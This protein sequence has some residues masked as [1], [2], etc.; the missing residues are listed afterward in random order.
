VGTKLSVQVTG[1]KTGLDPLTVTSPETDAVQLG[2]VVNSG[3]PTVV[4]TPQVGEEL[5]VDEG[6]WSPSDVSF[7]YQWLANNI[8]ISGAT[9]PTFTPRTTDVGKKLSVRVKGTRPGL[10]TVTVTS[11]QA[12]PVVAGAISNSVAPSTT[13][14]PQVGK[15]F[16][17]DPGTWAP[18]GVTLKYAW[19]ADGVALATALS[20]SYTP[21]PADLGKHLT[22]KVTASKTGYASMSVTTS[23]SAAVAPA[24][25]VNTVAPAISGTAKVGS[26]LTVS[27]G[28]W[29][30]TPS[31][32]AFQWYRDGVPIVGATAQT[33]LLTE[34][35]SGHD[36]NASVTVAKP[37]YA[38]STAAST[39]VEVAPIAVRNTAK[40]KITGTPKVG[41]TLTATPGTWAPAGVTVAYQW[42]AGG[43]EIDGADES[44]FV[45]TSAQVGK[46]LTVRATATRPGYLDGVATSLQTTVV[47]P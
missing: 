10:N 28:S 37:G 34:N 36:V 26:R 33:F 22:V 39:S 45:P 23:P 20:A 14:T 9:S 46:A 16:V 32:F 17:V 8:V 24:E 7:T 42:L 4:G 3:P 15:A 19:Y 40:P 13:G 5:S 25:L 35:E 41:T 6:T 29:S 27:R 44:T 12:A 30:A 2:A 1:S 31:S 43:V 47:R 11:A 38:T 18:T 21:K